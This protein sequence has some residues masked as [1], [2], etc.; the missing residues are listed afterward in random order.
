M[1]RKEY[2]M[3]RP[4]NCR[5]IKSYPNYWIF[6]AADNEN[7]ESIC[8]S[9]EEYEAIRLIDYMGLSQEEAAKSMEI[10]RP[11]INDT[12]QSARAKLAE[13]LVEGKNINISG[14]FYSLK[15]KGMKSLSDKGEEIMRI[16]T[17]FKDGNVSDHF[18]KT[19]FFK[20]FDVEDGKIVKDEVLDPNGKARGQLIELLKANE[21]DVL[22]CG[23]IGMGAIRALEEAGIKCL[24][25]CAGE[26]KENVE[27]YLDNRL[28]TNSDA[29]HECHHADE[30]EHH[31]HEGNHECGHHHDEDHECGHHHHGEGHK[32]CHED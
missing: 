21:V 3:P 5:R 13:F 31:H 20:I 17:T 10:S 6:E 28:A 8:M 14:G 7:D 18:G 15:E 26:A 32:C 24:P 30:H 9:L 29:V 27:A 2:F 11:S 1:I 16:A 12:Y 4:K 19:E 22:I 23:T 25:G